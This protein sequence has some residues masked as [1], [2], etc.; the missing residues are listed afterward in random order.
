[1]I[2]TP[3]VLVLGA[4]ASQPYG[5]PTGPDLRQLLLG[6]SSNLDAIAFGPGQDGKAKAGEFRRAFRRSRDPIDAFL[7]H[8]VEWREAGKCLIAAHISSAEQEDNLYPESGDWMTRFFGWM[9]EDCTA[10]NFETNQLRVITFNYDRSYEFALHEFIKA[11]FRVSAKEANRVAEPL[12]V[13]HVH[14][15]IGELKTDDRRDGRP[16][17]PDL[18]DLRCVASSIRVISDDANDEILRRA[19]SRLQVAHRVYCLGF[20]YHKVSVKRLFGAPLPYYSEIRGTCLGC[21]PAEQRVIRSQ[22]PIRPV[23]VDPRADYPERRQIALGEPTLDCD[24]FLRHFADR[25]T[26]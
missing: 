11:H 23:E 9:A 13:V 20:G 3:T 17:K 8:N 4:G 25:I 16:F 5:F 7:E 24:M 22:F 6:V 26:E 21:T 12:E 2:K 19:V 1:M 10:A 15:S 18:D 14:G